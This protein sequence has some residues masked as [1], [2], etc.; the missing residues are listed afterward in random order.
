MAGRQGGRERGH[1]RRRRHHHHHHAVGRD[2][3]PWMEREI[4]E[5]GVRSLRA[6]KSRDSIPPGS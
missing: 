4:G 1:P 3:A 2:H 5:A 6:L